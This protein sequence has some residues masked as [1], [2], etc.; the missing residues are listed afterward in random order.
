MGEERVRY[1]SDNTKDIESATSQ[2]ER[3]QFKYRGRIYIRPLER[4]VVLLDMPNGKE[5]Y[6]ESVV[7]EMF[8]GRVNDQGVF[9]VEII[10]RE[11]SQKGE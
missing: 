2:P 7:G 1:R 9:K 10:I 3:K 4:G 8:T 6:L 11:I 5:Q